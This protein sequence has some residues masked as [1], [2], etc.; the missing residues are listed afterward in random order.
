[1]DKN[2]KLHFLNG[3][4][5]AFNFNFFKVGKPNFKTHLD[6]KKNLEND[7]NNISKD[8]LGVTNDF[9]ERYC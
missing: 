3:I 9:K 2:A 6:D 4:L 5:L 7:F 8:F 1:M